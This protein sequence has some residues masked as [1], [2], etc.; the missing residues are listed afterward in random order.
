M[1]AVILAGGRGSRIEEE[2]AVR[3]KP[4][5]EIGGYPIIWHVMNIYAAA[6][7]KDFVICAGY[8]GYLIKEYF[9]RLNLHQGDAQGWVWTSDLT[10]GYV[11]INAHYRS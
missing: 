10:H 2:S 4:L 3:P 9:S 8:K 5:V 7:I 1:K 11:T 6:G